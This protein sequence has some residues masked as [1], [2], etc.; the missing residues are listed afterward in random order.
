MCVWGIHVVGIIKRD[1]IFWVDLL[2]KT[3]FVG[4][5]LFT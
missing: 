4:Q 1:G 3:N 2:T 5:K